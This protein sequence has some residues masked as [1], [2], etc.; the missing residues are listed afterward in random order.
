MLKKIGIAAAVAVLVAVVVRGWVVPALR[1]PPEVSSALA[2]SGEAMYYLGISEGRAAIFGQDRHT[3]LAQLDTPLRTL[4]AEER[5][6][7]SR[8][9]PIYSEAEL[10]QYLEDYS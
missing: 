6:R 7:L 1:E 9:I 2:E 4:P 10:Q 8:G 5:L 3:V